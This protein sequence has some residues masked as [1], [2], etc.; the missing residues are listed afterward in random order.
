[1]VSARDDNPYGHPSPELLSLL[2]DAGLLVARTDLDGSVAV[3]VDGDD[4]RVVGAPD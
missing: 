1:M 2:E 4:L 3:V